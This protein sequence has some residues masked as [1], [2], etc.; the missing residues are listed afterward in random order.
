MLSAPPRPFGCGWHHPIFFAGGGR[1]RKTDSASQV[2]LGFM[3]AVI[4]RWRG[5]WIPSHFALILPL[6]FLVEGIWRESVLHL[7]FDA[8][9]CPW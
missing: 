2:G 1:E 8:E 6:I 5:S 9:S 4:G 3:E 7:S